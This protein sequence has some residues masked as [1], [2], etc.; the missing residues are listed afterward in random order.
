MNNQY[1]YYNNVPQGNGYYPPQ[2]GYYVQQNNSMMNYNG[3]PSST[4]KKKVWILFFV[5]LVVLVI[6]G[7][8][9][10]KKTSV[11]KSNYTF[12]TLMNTD[13]FFLKNKD[14]AYALF[15]ESGKKITDFQFSKV[16]E[17]YGGTTVVTNL[18]GKNAIIREDGSY[19]V[20]FTEDT[21]TNYYSLFL[22]RPKDDSLVRLINYEGKELLEEEIIRVTSFEDSSVFVVSSGDENVTIMNYNGDRIDQLSKNNFIKSPI[23]KNGNVTLATSEKTYLYNVDTGKKIYETDG[24]YCLSKNV[25]TG[26]VLSSC[27]SPDSVRTYKTIKDNKELHS[28]GKAICSAIEVMED[29]NFICKNANDNA[30]HFINANGSIQK[31]IVA[32]YHNSKDYV[33][34]NGTSLTFYVDNKERYHVSCATIDKTVENGYIVKNYTY[35]ECSKSKGGEAFYNRAGEQVSESFYHA[36]EWDDNNMAIVSN[37]AGNYYLINANYEKVS[38]DYR[39]IAVVDTLY[40]VMDENRNY[41]LINSKQKELEQGFKNYRQIERGIGKENYVALIYQDKFVLY[42][43]T[44]GDKVSENSGNNINL[45]EHYYK[46]DDGY[47]SYETGKQFYKNE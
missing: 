22:I 8:Y 2:S 13:S 38:R 47:Y 36:T 16:G 37:K 4:K 26:F 25:T 45:Y 7:F 34:K 9:V 28:I 23:V 31:D 46:I 5:I 35:G 1:G 15:D 40:M 24:T 32:G 10:W 43:S 33:I 19:L 27:S 21:I 12:D 41:H 17:F 42:N 20:D 29:G 44:T 11:R 39:S 30:Y 14:G 18:E 6:V 3:T